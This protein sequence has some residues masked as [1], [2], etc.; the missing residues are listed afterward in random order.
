MIS[1]GLVQTL[2]IVAV[3][4]GSAQVGN[5]FE[6]QSLA[7]SSAQRKHSWSRRPLSG[8]DRARIRPTNM[9]NCSGRTTACILWSTLE[10]ELLRGQTGD[11]VKSNCASN[12]DIVR[13]EFALPPSAG[14]WQ[15][16][17][18]DPL[19]APQQ[20]PCSLT[21]SVPHSIHMGPQESCSKSMPLRMPSSSRH[22]ESSSHDMY[23][24]LWRPVS[25]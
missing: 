4:V 8:S 11:W 12:G 16:L 20:R 1:N 10:F 24:K 3:V 14:A 13:H 17:V 25:C 23:C 2:S 18:S 7:S 9:R 22:T 5:F 6:W 15:K 21:G 19:A